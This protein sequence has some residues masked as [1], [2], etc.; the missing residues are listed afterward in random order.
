[1]VRLSIGLWSRFL[2]LTN[3]LFGADFT[4]SVTSRKPAKLLDLSFHG[5]KYEK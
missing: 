3:G 5:I 1:M 2:A 4:I